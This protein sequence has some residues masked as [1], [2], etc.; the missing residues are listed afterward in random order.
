VIAVL[1]LSTVAVMAVAALVIPRVLDAQWA[2]ECRRHA[3][4]HRK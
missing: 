1:A 4:R 2:A 3:A